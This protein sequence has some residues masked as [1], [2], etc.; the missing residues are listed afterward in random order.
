[1][2]LLRPD[3]HID[4]PYGPPIVLL[5]NAALNADWRSDVIQLSRIRS[6]SVHVERGLTIAGTLSLVQAN[7]NDE[8]K[9]RA[10]PD[11]AFAAIDGV[12]GG[13]CLDF[14]NLEAEYYQFRF[15]RSAGP[16]SLWIA[17]KVKG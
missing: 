1:M 8:L 10:S 11:V 15:V 17:I 4:N 3:G 6:M 7:V 16:G 5:D 2:G 12:A 9:M 14:Y 13:E